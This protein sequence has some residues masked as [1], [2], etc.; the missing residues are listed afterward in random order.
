VGVDRIPGNHS[1]IAPNPIF[2]DNSHQAVFRSRNFLIHLGQQ[3]TAS[4][5][6]GVIA[7]DGR[8][9]AEGGLKRW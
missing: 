5:Y 3:R 1:P 7:L 4:H 6:L 9:R 2:L 8:G